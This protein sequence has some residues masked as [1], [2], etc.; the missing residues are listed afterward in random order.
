MRQG[1]VALG[2]DGAAPLWASVSSPGR[3]AVT[4]DPALCS[5][6]LSASHCA[7]H[8]VVGMLLLM[9]I[10]TMAVA[11]LMV[12]ERSTKVSRG[13]RYQVLASFP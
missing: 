3:V 6:F 11:M 5:R 4:R 10:V 13:I 1:C 8:I 7:W 12:M 9:V 2:T